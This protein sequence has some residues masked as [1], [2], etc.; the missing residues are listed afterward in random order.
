MI[1]CLEES[2]CRCYSLHE[3]NNSDGHHPLVKDS[4]INGSGLFVH[5]EQVIGHLQG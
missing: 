1:F 3:N 5:M 2:G 4:G